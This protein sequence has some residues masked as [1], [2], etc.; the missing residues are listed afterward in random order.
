[1]D[2]ATVPLVVAAL[3]SSD[4]RVRI[5]SARALGWMKE[6][7]AVPAL[8]AV[9]GDKTAPDRLR[10]VAADALGWIGGPDARDAPAAAPRTG[11]APDA[12]EGY[13]GRALARLALGRLADAEGD[14]DR[15]VDAGG[16]TLAAALLNR[17]EVRRR[18]GNADG[19]LSDLD[20]LIKKDPERA[21]ARLARG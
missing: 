4:A 16:A 20:T 2:A 15:V 5:V 7:Q 12:V 8:A 11:A 14:L 9:V 13:L 19:A 17:A 10:F 18:R 6:T 1:H 3:Q 21:D